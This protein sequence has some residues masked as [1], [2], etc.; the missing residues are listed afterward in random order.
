MCI[1]N[2]LIGFNNFSF[3]NEFIALRAMHLG[4]PVPSNFY[5]NKN[6]WP[7]FGQCR[8]IAPYFWFGK[9]PKK[10][11]GL[12]AIAKFLGVK[13]YSG[14]VNGS[15]FYMFFNSKE[16]KDRE[17][18]IK[19]AVS[20]SRAT[21]EIATKFCYHDEKTAVSYDIETL[22]LSDPH[23][24][25]IAG[26]FDPEDVKLGNTKDPEKVAAKIDQARKDYIKNLRAGAA[27]DPQTGSI[28]CISLSSNEADRVLSGTEEEILTT[29]FE[30]FNQGQRGRI[31]L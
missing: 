25:D 4:V 16:E 14:I 1:I 29:F 18:A 11:R 27:L 28:A 22:P 2:E 21:Y 24:L 12:K 20:D 15:N 17:E 3:D 13:M 6:G 31:K 7:D 30:L 10:G 5:M 23:L 9:S 19:Y 26:P 8:D